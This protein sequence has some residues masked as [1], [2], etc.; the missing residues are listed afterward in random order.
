MHPIIRLVFLLFLLGFFSHFATAQGVYIPLNRDY[1]HLIERYEIKSGQWADGIH[2][3]IKPYLRKAVIQ[4]ADSTLTRSNFL[5]ERDRFNLAYLQADSWEWSQDTV[6]A[7]SKRPLLRHLYTRKADFYSFRNQ[8]VEVHVNPVLQLGAGNDNTANYTPYINT[9]GVEVRGMVDGKIGFYAFITENQTAPPR[10]VGQYI[11][12]Y[13]AFPGE[14]YVRPFSSDANGSDF[15]TARGYIAFN[16]TRHIQVQLGHDRN[17]IGNGYRSLILSD[18][19]ANYFFLKLSTQV[20]KFKYTNLF[21]QLNAGTNAEPEKAYPHKY[22]AFHHLSVNLGKRFNLGVFESVISGKP[23]SLGGS[24]L[25]LEYLNPIIFYRAIEL[26]T[27]SNEG[28]ALLGFDFKW[29][30]MRHFLFYGQV[31]LDEFVLKEV[32]AGKGWWA[33]KQ[34]FQLGVKYF[35]AFGIPN[36]DLHTEL[37]VVR[38]FTYTHTS[39]FTNYTHYN[40]PLAH[41]LGANF[42]EVLGIVRY[43]P[44]N[45]LFVTAKLVYSQYGDDPDRV[46]GERLTSVGRNVLLPY[47]ARDREYGYSIGN[48]VPTRLLY[49]DLTLSYMLRH[50]LFIEARQVFRKLDSDISSRNLNTSFSFLS[51]R[52]NIPSREQVF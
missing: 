14:N 22:L 5:S 34:A 35:D 43:Q 23:D 42:W 27:G 28:N 50:N 24:N 6:S 10:Y 38:P 41:P 46:E 26:N 1:E 39:Q 40:Q 30:A 17:M 18:F 33:N 44:L 48:G 32:R 7:A 49:A 2:T 15:V 25:N 52:C 13:N 4:L 12:L 51:L 3:H 11:R 37:N 9:R 29:Q 21:A 31:V 45:R 16:A 36:L 8:V 20:W 19:G 47:T